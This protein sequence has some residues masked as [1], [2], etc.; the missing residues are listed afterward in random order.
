LR[1]N[2]YLKRSFVAVALLSGLF[3]SS[4]S[5]QVFSN[6]DVIQMVGAQVPESVIIARINGTN[7]QMDAST[8]AIVDLARAGASVGVIEAVMSKGN[9]ASQASETPKTMVSEAA[10][11]EFVSISVS[12]S[13]IRI[14]VRIKSKFKN[15]LYVYGNQS[16]ATLRNAGGNLAR[17]SSASLTDDAGNDFQCASQTLSGYADIYG[18]GTYDRGGQVISP[19]RSINVQY[20][21]DVPAGTNPGQNF[22]FSADPYMLPWWNASDLTDESNGRFGNKITIAFSFQDIKRPALQVSSRPK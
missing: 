4:A 14:N 10:D 15:D 5:A 21:F 16:D 18:Y 2:T 1:K 12:Q 6:T 3:V 22:A 7:A 11:V 17:C 13:L 9:G 8:R 20:V 19:Y